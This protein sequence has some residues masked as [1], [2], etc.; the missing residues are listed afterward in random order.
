MTK[1]RL[2]PAA[3]EEALARALALHDLA[4]CVASALEKE[5]R[6]EKMYTEKELDEYALKLVTAAETI[7]ATQ[8]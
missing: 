5:M 7:T 1:L 3:L 2:A 8:Q 4:Q 6:G